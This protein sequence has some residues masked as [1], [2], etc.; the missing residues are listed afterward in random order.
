VRTAINSGAGLQRI[1]GVLAGRAR[2]GEDV[3]IPGDWPKPR[4]EDEWRTDFGTTLAAGGRGTA[5]A[6]DAGR[7]LVA[8]GAGPARRHVWTRWRRAAW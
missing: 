7:P 4:L 8:H 1:R 6:F 5:A 2:L 3:R